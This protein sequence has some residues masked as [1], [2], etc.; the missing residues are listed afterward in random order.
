MRD[1]LL[2]TSFVLRAM[3]SLAIVSLMTIKPN[4]GTSLGMIGAAIAVAAGLSMP[5]WGQAKKVARA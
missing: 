5:F 4:L 2:A 3:L 1:P